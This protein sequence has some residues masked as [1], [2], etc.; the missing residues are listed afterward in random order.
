MS[1]TGRFLVFTHSFPDSIQH[2][3]L[4]NKYR[5]VDPLINS[6]LPNP[7]EFPERLGNENLGV[8]R[9]P[10]LTD[11]NFIILDFFNLSNSSIYM[12]AP[13]ARLLVGSGGSEACRDWPPL[14]G[15]ARVRRREAGFSLPFKSQSR[16]LKRRP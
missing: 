8:N 4:Q 2:L 10:L 5:I 1:K 13:R 9:S 16:R 7:S 15:R 12:P 6:P 11:F 3:S 14:E